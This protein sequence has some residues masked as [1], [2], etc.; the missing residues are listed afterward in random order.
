MLFP[1]LAWQF[2][3]PCGIVRDTPVGFR[4]IQY[5]G[6]HAV[7]AEDD[8][9]APRLCEHYLVALFIFGGLALA[10]SGDPSLRGLA[11]DRGY[12][13]VSPFGFHPF[14]PCSFEVPVMA[15]LGAELLLG[16]PCRCQLPHRYLP[17]SG[18]DV[19]A[20]GLGHGDPFRRPVLRIYLAANSPPPVSVCVPS[21]LR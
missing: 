20:F 4:V 7:G 21:G 15:G 17:C 12:R 2:D 6:E 13:G 1:A 9:G 3:A 8:A 14:L 10:D 11:G 5:S 19:R 16:Q 18:I